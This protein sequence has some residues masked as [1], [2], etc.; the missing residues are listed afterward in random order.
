[1]SKEFL[2]IEIPL[3]F[4]KQYFIQG[5]HFALQSRAK[6]RDLIF[7]ARSQIHLRGVAPKEVNECFKKHSENHPARRNEGWQKWIE[8][9]RNSTCLRNC[10]VCLVELDTSK[11]PAG[12]QSFYTRC[13]PNFEKETSYTRAAVRKSTGFGFMAEIAKKQAGTKKCTGHYLRTTAVTRL[14]ESN[15][16]YEEIRKISGHK[17]TK[18]LGAYQKLSRTWN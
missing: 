17:N 3:F 6:H 2:E 1:M 11:V 14:L 16:K 4:W 7:G 12:A 18:S 10:P 8:E 5:K 15:I 13:S 9:R